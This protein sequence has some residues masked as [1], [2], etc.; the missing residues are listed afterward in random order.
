MTE[1][2]WEKAQRYES[3]WGLGF[4]GQPLPSS[5]THRNFPEFLQRDPQLLSEL[6]LQMTGRVCLE[7]GCGPTPLIS[8]WKLARRRLIVD[9]LL[10]TYLPHLRLPEEVEVISAPG[11]QALTGLAGQVDGVLFDCNCIDH[12]EDPLAL[13]DL[14]LA[15][16]APGCWL[17]HWSDIW[18]YPS[19]DEGHR[20]ISEDRSVLR[21]FVT[22]RDFNIHHEFFLDRGQPPR[23][24]DW[25]CLARKAV[26]L[27]PA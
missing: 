12:A 5:F 6:D 16:A 14:Y 23:Q 26:R 15:C 22:S 8:D 24:L 7:L 17:M 20:N 19:P 11:E 2:W 9:P 25:G 1:S 13:F 21:A 3:A 4:L 18:H 27:S 10:S